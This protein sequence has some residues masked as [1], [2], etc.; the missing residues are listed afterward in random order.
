MLFWQGAW[1][2]SIFYY[3]R[4]FSFLFAAGN[5]REYN[6]RWRICVTGFFTDSE[7]IVYLLSAVLLV[8]VII[9]FLIITVERWLLIILNALDTILTRIGFGTYSAR[10]L[11][12]AENWLRDRKTRR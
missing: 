10:A 2:A 7:K 1:E 6:I 12:S 3:A 9:A 4:R 5:R 8:A 11:T